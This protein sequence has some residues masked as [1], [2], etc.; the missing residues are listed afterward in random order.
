VV[1]ILMNLLINAA[2]A[3]A[4]QRPAKPRI[5]VATRL[6]GDQV[7]ISVSDNG[8]GIAPDHL[9]QVFDEHFTTK[10]P[11]RGS[12]LGLSVCRRLAREDGGEIRLE[13]ALGQGTTARILLPVAGRQNT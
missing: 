12:G 11:G 5:A 8:P 2:D 1:Q 9:A 3:L 4:D 7:E 6:D 13:S 10:Q